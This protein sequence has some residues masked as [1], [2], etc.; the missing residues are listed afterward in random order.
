MGC[1]DIPKPMVMIG[2]RP[3]L[4]HIMK[5][6]A[7]AGMHNFI[8]LLGYKKD[9]II[10]YFR[11]RTP[12]SIRFVDT[13]LDTNTGGRL[14]RIEHLVRE[15]VFFATYGDGLADINLNSLFTFHRRHNKVATI[16]SVRP[17]SPFGIMGID[18]HTD[19]VTHFQ[20]KP[21]LDHWVNGGFFVFNRDV[22]RYLK[23]D[24]I[25]EK[26]S[27]LRLVKDKNMVAYKHRG[28]W[29]C[30]DTYKDNLK[31]NALWKSAEAPWCKMKRKI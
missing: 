24:D 13:G 29:E 26:D 11:K 30:M 3:I 12:W 14:K 27:F 5:I 15:D 31:L 9:A 6:Y 23:K 18:S 22:F 19:A 10:R 20:E 2:N 8:L 17:A 4:W 16:T 7:Q 28:F 21:F 25:L 1:D